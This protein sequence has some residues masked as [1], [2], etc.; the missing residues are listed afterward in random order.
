LGTT[1][2]ELEPTYSNLIEHLDMKNVG[3]STRFIANC[4]RYAKSKGVTDQ[5]LEAI[6]IACVGEMSD[7]HLN[8]F[9]TRSIT[10]QFTRQ[11]DGLPRQ[12]PT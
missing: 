7:K 4:I 10:D 1:V 11:I 3:A 9:E 6:F 8:E 12:L 2:S 5:Q